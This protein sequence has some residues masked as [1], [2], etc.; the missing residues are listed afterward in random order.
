MQHTI[1]DIIRDQKIWTRRAVFLPVDWVSKMDTSY[2]HLSDFLYTERFE[3]KFWD[4][5]VLFI[6]HNHGQH[7][8]LCA[9]DCLLMFVTD[10]AGGRTSII[11]KVAQQFCL[12]ANKKTTLTH[13]TLEC[14]DRLLEALMVYMKP[15]TSSC[16][17]Y[18]IYGW[19]MGGS[20]PK[21]VDVIF[22]L[23]KIYRIGWLLSK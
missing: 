3:M 12:T 15:Y 8:I 2:T 19:D 18:T 7:W 22:E 1:K 23:V 16:Q 6:L 5:S 20:G 11:I 4:K 9:K 21:P 17:P 14:T 10:L 13:H